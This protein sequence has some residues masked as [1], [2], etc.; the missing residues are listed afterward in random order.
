MKNTSKNLADLFS[1]Q[2]PRSY[3][4]GQIIIRPD[5]TSNGIFY[6]EKGHV[7]SYSLTEQGEQKNHIIYKTGDIF[8][9]IRSFIPTNRSVFFETIDNSTLKM[10][11]KEYFFTTIKAD[12]QILFEI[13]K[14]I[15]E[16]MKT[17]IERLDGLEYTKANSRIIDYLLF[18]ADHFGKRK[19]KKILIEVPITH[20]DIADSTAISRETVSREIEELKRKK[21]IGDKNKYILIKNI[22]KLERELKLQSD[23]KRL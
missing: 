12:A 17:H 8:P 14:K 21:L 3:K 11:E 13:T 10:M 23:P 20:K 5:D 1:E 22:K 7:K 16:I 18:L 6:L 15:I 19:G 2:H 4:K 9:L